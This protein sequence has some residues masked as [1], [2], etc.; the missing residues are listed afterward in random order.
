[1]KF[2]VSALVGVIIKVIDVQVLYSNTFLYSST[3]FEHLW[4][5]SGGQIVLVQ[6]LVSSL[7]LGDCAVHRLREDWLECL[8]E[9]YN[10]CIK[11]KNLCI[12]L[13]KKDNHQILC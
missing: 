9:E 6:H 11:I 4:L 10:E 7:S 12:K 8:A 1:M 13:V 3:C 2:Y 5:S